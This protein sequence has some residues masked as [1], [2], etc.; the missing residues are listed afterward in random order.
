MK[1]TLHVQYNIVQVSDGYAVRIDYHSYGLGSE[2]F[3][4]ANAQTA[5]A[6]VEAACDRWAA[7]GFS[8]KTAR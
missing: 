1:P 5:R 6:T 2:H 8:V 4:A 3:W 7:L